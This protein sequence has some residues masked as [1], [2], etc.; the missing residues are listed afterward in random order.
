MIEVVA[1]EQA[2]AEID[3]WIEY[4]KLTPTQI[5]AHKQSIETLIEG[6]QYGML[7]LK[8]NCFTQTLLFP[9][10]KDGQIKQL[11][12]GNR[13]NKLLL[14][15]HLK[16]VAADDGDERLISYLSC[17]TEKTDGV[18]RQHLIQLDSQDNR[19]AMS[20]VVFFLS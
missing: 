18:V 8:D 16:G 5:E 9:I 11:Q 10:G 20:I 13:V 3:A 19:I 4:R 7:T 12:Y 15:P 2:K 6:I 17:L 1:Y 14:A